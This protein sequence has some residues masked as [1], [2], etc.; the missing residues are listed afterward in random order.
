[1]RSIRREYVLR[2]LLPCLIALAACSCGKGKE[3]SA[4]PKTSPAA[5]AAP[6]ASSAPAAS[7]APAAS[8][9]PVASSATGP[10][11]KTTPSGTVSIS[12]LGFYDISQLKYPP[13]DTFENYLAWMKVNT[14]DKEKYL[15]ARW[16]RLAQDN[17]VHPENMVGIRRAFLLTPREDFIRSYTGRPFPARASL[18]A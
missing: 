2:A 17:D 13:M 1:M 9:A 7:A 5:S 18:S 11:V 6:A 4:S 15:R 10:G 3:A 8:S 12:A 16:D 14:K